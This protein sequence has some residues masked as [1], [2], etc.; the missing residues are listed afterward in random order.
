MT[1]PEKSQG[2]RDD[3]SPA[4]R[5]LLKRNVKRSVFAEVAPDGRRSLLKVFHAPGLGGL[6]DRGRA[7]R[8]GRAHDAVRAAGLPC[9]EAHGLERADGRWALRLGWIKGATPLH[10]AIG[11]G[12]RRA[13][14]ARRLAA[15][16]AA[17]ERAGLAHPDP[18][19]GNLLV[20]ATGEVFLA[21]LA[22]TR[23]GADAGALREQWLDLCGELRELDPRFLAA[24]DGRWR[25]AGAGTNAGPSE[26]L[27][28]AAQQRRVARMER[29]V[30]VWRRE[31]SATRVERQEG[32]DVVVARSGAPSG[33][34]VQRLEG[35]RTGVETAWSTLVRAT[36]HRLPTAAPLACSLEAPW[37]VDYAVPAGSTA[38]TEAAPR[39]R[40]ALERSGLRAAGPL[41]AD[42]SGETRVGPATRLTDSIAGGV[43]RA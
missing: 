30:R 10:Q 26:P 1:G 18:H 39:L 42:E 32:R 34:V 29:R 36:L 20:D 17:V 19:A 14:L 3:A 8:E 15:L 40:A 7:R 28:A 13:P 24:V 37:F 25:A 35:E 9:A 12:A 43:S 31:S 4:G 2:A 22:G 5:S 38:A 41:V 16:G 11:S 23:L 21:D 6:R 27:A 33:W